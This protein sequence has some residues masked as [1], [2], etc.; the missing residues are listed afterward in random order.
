MTVKPG[1]W[2][3]GEPADTGAG[4]DP[5]MDAACIRRMAA[6]EESGLA[7][8]YDRHGRAVYG[9]ACRILADSIE[10][11]DVVQD[12]FAQAWRQSTRFDPSR[13]SVTG[14]LF[15]I[16]RTRA[17]DRLRSRRVRPAAAGVDG[18]HEPADDG[19]TPEAAALTEDQRARVRQALDAL[20]APQR[21]AI[22][23]AYYGGLTQADIARELG[24]PLGTVKSR[25]RAALS[26]L[27]AALGP[28]S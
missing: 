17:L 20:D 16:A 4:P 28:R 26:R 23:M 3:A 10:A 1:G 19:P 27:R 18:A 21:T 8:L 6:G 9:L 25:M 22:E 12:V 14:W 13:A 24:E 5:Q 2:G 7:Q 11:E 15:M